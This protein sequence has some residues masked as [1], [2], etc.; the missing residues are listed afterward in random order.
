MKKTETKNYLTFANIRVQ[1][2]LV[3]LFWCGSWCSS[4]CVLFAAVLCIV[5]SMLSILCCPFDVLYR[6]LTIYSLVC[7]LCTQCWLYRRIFHS[8]IPFRCSLSFTYYLLFVLCLVYSM[9]PISHDCPFLVA[10]SIFSILY[11]L[12]TV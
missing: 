8:W 12:S 7:V 3:L 10:P 9:L 11:L 2:A 5:N 4:C 1:P 6:L